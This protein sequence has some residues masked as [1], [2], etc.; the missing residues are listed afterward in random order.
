V[1]TT[2]FRCLVT[3]SRDWADE[4][5][6]YAALDAV[7]SG[8]VGGGYA[9]LIVVHGAAKGADRMSYRWYRSRARRGWAVA[10]EAHSAQWSEHGRRAGIVRNQAM[11]RLGAD[12]VLA[13]I[14]PCADPKCG[15]AQ[16]HGSHGA[17]HCADLAEGDGIHVQR[18]EPARADA[19]S[20]PNPERR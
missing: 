20:L 4:G 1:T 12:V 9:G 2:W 16:P 11:V 5:A 18:F 13:F 17:T 15:R 14:A 7:W 6:V 10:H 3:G 19:G 8:A